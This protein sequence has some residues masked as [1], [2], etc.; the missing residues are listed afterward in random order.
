MKIYLDDVRM[1]PEGWHRCYKIEEIQRLLCEAL[2][3]GEEITDMSLDHDLGCSYL[4][5]ECHDVGTPW[6]ATR[7]CNDDCTCACHASGYPLDFP[8][9]YDLV[10]WMARHD[11]WPTNK[12][13]V[14]SANPAGRV[15]M[16]ATID[17]YWHPPD[18]RE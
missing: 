14:H 18:E 11:M 8:S 13:K 12:P 9:G 7:Q 15:N 5:H 10:K 2:L 16:Q 4:C 1:T 3:G 17:R 6:E